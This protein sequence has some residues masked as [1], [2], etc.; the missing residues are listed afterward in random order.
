MSLVLYKHY[1]RCTRRFTK[2]IL[3][4]LKN[5][6]F[7][8]LVFK[9]RRRKLGFRLNFHPSDRFSSF[10]AFGVAE[11]PHRS[12]RA[13]LSVR[14]TDAEHSPSAFGSRRCSPSLSARFSHCRL[15]LAAPRCASSH[16][17]E[18]EILC[19]TYVH[20]LQRTT[21]TAFCRFSRVSVCARARV[22]VPLAA[23]VRRYPTDERRS[24]GS[25][26][27]QPL[28]GGGA[29]MSTAGPYV[30]DAAFNAPRKVLRR[31]T[32]RAEPPRTF[33]LVFIYEEYAN[34]L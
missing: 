34:V 16:S 18:G 10:V 6:C 5:K 26:A 12:R 28:G 19:G 1:T 14:D 29:L 15:A 2:K 21:P 4:R 25:S 33:K 17:R 11:Y 30:S 22:V 27:S 20:N 9:K 32:Q 13:R 7:K 8:K 3:H 24:A 31:E 23:G